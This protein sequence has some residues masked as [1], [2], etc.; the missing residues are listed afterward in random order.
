MFAA[1]LPTLVQVLPGLIQTGFDIFSLAK[2]G[3]TIDPTTPTESF[4]SELLRSLPALLDAGADVLA[5]VTAASASI[6]KQKAEN[7][8]PTDAERKE[9]IER[10]AA[11]DAAFDKAAAPRLPGT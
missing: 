8:G 11:H 10:I 5:L 7:R 9:Q 6:A 1:I 4:A 2:H 3:G